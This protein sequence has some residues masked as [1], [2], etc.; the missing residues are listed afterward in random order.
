MV[1]AVVAILPSHIFFCI[2]SSF[3]ITTH[4]VRTY[5][6][7]LPPYQFLLHQILLSLLS[8]S[9][10]QKLPIYQNER[11]RGE[12]ERREKREYRSER[13]RKEKRE[14]RRERERRE[15]REVWFSLYMTTFTL[16][17]MHTHTRILAIESSSPPTNSIS[18]PVSLWQMCP[19]FWCQPP[20]N[21]D[22]D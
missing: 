2:S 20:S 18:Q 3:E 17:H 5:L 7:I 4:T 13:E 6:S 11:E 1:V 14:Y 15:E 16:F 22:G 12:R 10:S 21:R 19:L 8:L 9:L